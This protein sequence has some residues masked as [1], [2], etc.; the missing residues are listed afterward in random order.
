MQS[1]DYISLS[2]QLPLFSI[3]FG[4]PLSKVCS[5]YV[6]WETPQRQLCITQSGVNTQTVQFLPPEEV[7]LL[8]PKIPDPVETL[9]IAAAK[10][11][12]L[13]DDEEPE[14]VVCCEEGGGGVIWCG[15]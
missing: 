7:L 14:G 2:A 12:E 6:T 9:D 11:L 15:Y 5:V 4:V 13:L 3:A 1:S 8:E 10:M